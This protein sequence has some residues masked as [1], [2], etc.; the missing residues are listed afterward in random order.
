MARLHYI[1]AFMNYLQVLVW[2][3]SLAVARLLTRLRNAPSLKPTNRREIQYLIGMAEEDDKRPESS[4]F[5]GFTTHIYFREGPDFVVPTS[6]IQKCPKLVPDGARWPPSAIRV[7]DVTSNIAHIIFYYL[8]TG[9]YQSLR[10]KGSSH[11]EKLGNELKTGVQSYNA[12][13]TYELPALQ[14]L[15]KDEIQRLAQELPFPLVLNLLRNLHLDP[16]ER[17]TWLDDYVQ[18]GLKHLF[19]TPTAFLDLTA[20][21]VEH[22]VVSFSNIILKSLA[23]LLSNEVVLTQKDMPPMPT[24]EPAAI[25]DQPNHQE[26]LREQLLREE[27]PGLVEAAARNEEP[28]HYAEVSEPIKEPELPEIEAE[29]APVA[30][31][32]PEPEPEPALEPVI[33]Q[34][35][36]ELKHDHAYDHIDE[37]VPDLTADEP[38]SEPAPETKSE[39]PGAFTTFGA[40]N[41]FKPSIW[42]WGTDTTK[43]KTESPQPE[44]EPI[45]SPPALVESPP[46]AVPEPIPEARDTPIE[47]PEPVSV[48]DFSHVLEHQAPADDIAVP[49]TTTPEPTK[50]AETP[51]GRTDSKKRLSLFRFATEPADKSADSRE[52]SRVQTPEPAKPV[53]VEAPKVEP[54]VEDNKG[55]SADDAA[56][57]GSSASAAADKKKKKKKKSLFYRSDVL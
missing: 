51:V 40:K 46:E 12:A 4:P 33:E 5:A 41:G 6:L 55:V 13:R 23:H 29:P 39:E 15:A 9:T 7:D 19:Q 14:E 20:A 54:R 56:S 16:C 22:D 31:P 26:S 53:P 50:R 10:P 2:N 43:P 21:Q 3:Y 38:A 32:A 57:P 11:E 42:D 35:A 45:S 24:L 36:P 37:P 48:R 18:A 27:T 25:E 30:E 8:L 52:S 34:P 47:Y 44:D 1:Q 17:E 49:S 28:N